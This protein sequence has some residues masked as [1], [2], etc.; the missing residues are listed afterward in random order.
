MSVRLSAS[1][2]GFDVISSL[3]SAGSLCWRR[4]EMPRRDSSSFPVGTACV[5]GGLRPRPDAWGLERQTDI[6]APGRAGGRRGKERCQGTCQAWKQQPGDLKVKCA[7]RVS[8]LRRFLLAGTK[9]DDATRNLAT[10][11]ARPH[12]SCSA[13]ASRSRWRAYCTHTAGVLASD[14]WVRLRIHAHFSC[15]K[16]QSYREQ[17]YSSSPTI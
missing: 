6:T 14:T 2:W 12:S 17:Y 13:R 7:N 3:L 15:L 10:F 1:G 11:L 16:L 4:R 5:S 9:R 8:A